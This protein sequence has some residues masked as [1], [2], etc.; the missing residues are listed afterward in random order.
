MPLAS[1]DLMYIGCNFN[2]ID[3][4]AFEAHTD[5]NQQEMTQFLF[6]MKNLKT[7]K[8][9]KVNSKLSFNDL[10][11]LIEYPHFQKLELDGANLTYQDVLTLLT[12]NKRP[13][14]FLKCKQTSLNIKEFVY[15]TNYFRN[16]KLVCQI[17]E[18]DKIK[19][20]KK[21]RKCLYKIGRAHV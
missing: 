8:I 19:I 9:Y 6:S 1:K 2:Y 17:K 12:M 13:S 7:L 11:N 10:Q 15:I 18:N 16:K 21:V 20:M 5:S 3:Y 14:F 4:L